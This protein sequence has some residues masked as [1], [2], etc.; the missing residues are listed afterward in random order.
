MSDSRPG[1]FDNGG[2]L[3]SQTLLLGNAIFESPA[4]PGRSKPPNG[5]NASAVSEPQPIGQLGEY[6]L[7]KELG[8][9]GMGVV[10][11]AMQ[12]SLN[13]RVAVKT[14][15]QTARLEP[16]QV[17]RFLHEAQAAAQLNHPHIVPVFSVG[18]ADGLHYYTMQLIEGRDVARYIRE[19]RSLCDSGER[20]GNAE[21]PVN[22]KRPTEPHPAP[23]R[24]NSFSD[25]VPGDGTTVSV[26]VAKFA[27]LLPGKQERTS[28]RNSFDEIVQIGIQ[29]AEALHYAHQVGVVHRDVKPSNL[30]L[31]HEGKLW[32][33]DFGLAQVQGAAAMTMTGEVVGTLRYMSPEQPLGQRVLLD[34]RTDI[35]S[36]GVTL[37]ELLTLEKAFGGTT[38]REIIRQV[39]FDEPIRIRRRNSRVPED[40]ET[41]V[42]KAM[43]KNPDERYQTAR[44]LAD[45]LERFRQDQAILARR[46]TLL[47]QGRR[48]VR[49]NVA[50]ATAITVGL[51][52]LL[53]VS[54]SASG[55]I[56]SA[57]QAETQQRQKVE[58]ALK[59]SEGLRLAASSLLVNG[60]NPGLAL[61]LA[62]R[63][64]ELYPCVDTNSAL[65]TAMSGNHELFSF[66]PREKRSAALSFSPDGK[67]I[68]SATHLASAI[69]TTL[70]LLESEPTTG[71]LLRTYDDGGSMICGVYSPDG[72]LMLSTSLIS[73]DDGA[74]PKTA[75]VRCVLWDTETGERRFTFSD[76]LRNSCCDRVFSSAR[77][78]V[79]IPGSDGTVKVFSTTDGRLMKSLPGHTQPVVC[80]SF[81]QR[82]D[83]I[84]SAS[85]DESVRVWSS[86]TGQ[87]IQQF[88][89]E[90]GAK[91]IRAEI[92]KSD[93]EVLISSSKGT[94]VGSV[95]TGQPRNPDHL[96]ENTAV[97]DRSGTTAALYLLY[98]KHVNIVDVPSCQTMAR[99]VVDSPIAH[100]EFSADSKNL[101]VCTVTEAI[102]A[103]AATGQIH[104]RLR[105]HTGAMIEAR[106]SP[107][108]RTVVSSS[109]DKT[110]RHW[111]LDNW[112]D[113][114]IISTEMERALP[115]PWAI[116]ADS[117]QIAVAVRPREFTELRDADGKLINASFP[118]SVN[119][120]GINGSRLVT[121]DDHEIVVWNSESLQQVA[122]L[123]LPSEQLF[124]ARAVPRTDL[125][126]ALLHDRPP[127]IW[128]IRTGDKTYVKEAT[129]QPSDMDLH[130]RDSIVAVCGRNGDCCL[131]DAATARVTQAFHQQRDCGTVRFSP[132][133][134]NI[135]T[136]DSTNTIV[137]WTPEQN[138]NRQVFRDEPSG[139]LHAAWG[140]DDTTI[141]AWRSGTISDLRCLNTETGAEL[142]RLPDATVSGLSVHPAETVAAI[143]SAESGLRLWNWTTSDIRTL[144]TAPARTPVFHRGQLYA[145]EGSADFQATTETL[146]GFP[147]DLKFARSALSIRDGQTGQLKEST[148]LTMLVHLL[149]ADPESGRIAVSG[150]NYI[151]EVSS[152]EDGNRI[153]DIRQ[154]TAPL[155]FITFAGNTTRL[156]C[157]GLDGRISVGDA[158]G[159]RLLPERHN[160]PIRIAQVS[161]DGGRLA[162]IDTSGTG[163]L[164][165]LDR[166]EFIL[167]L[168]RMEAA[169]NVLEMSPSN[170][171]LAMGSADGTLV[172]FDLIART[173]ISVRR[174]AA[175]AEV[176]WSEDG[177]QLLV[178][179]EQKN[180]DPVTRLAP[181]NVLVLNA[182]TL[183]ATSIISVREPRLA[184]WR[185]GRRQIGIV[186]DDGRLV[187]HDPVRNASVIEMTMDRRRI[188]DMAFSPNGQDLLLMHEDELSL[189]NLDSQR[190]QL[191][192]PS[193][194][195][196]FLNEETKPFRRWQPFSPDGKWILS[197]TPA[198][199]KS[200]RV[201]LEEARQQTLRPLSDSE[202]KQYSVGT[203]IPNL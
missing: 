8:R 73:S 83:R 2:E 12:P 134:R 191:R 181:R 9:G 182:Q 199:K 61:L 161:R 72:R 115:Y 65:M 55:M 99:I 145:V 14:L 110:I 22:A 71:K 137:V 62:A 89:L 133:G 124:A 38:S 120:R 18:I 97:A 156:I 129:D 54:L 132:S 131:I 126:V 163:F 19:A 118:G 121:H 111:S 25:S 44:E 57:L 26:P 36:L 114:Q 53:L 135:L 1:E 30:M 194:D 178:V 7:L 122:S 34:Q 102:V 95:E 91:N 174:D 198:L 60:S 31:D 119:R 195:K 35:Y 20:R 27:G 116:S 157:G 202:R 106:F 155:P 33:T 188:S 47:Q 179:T 159:Q 52:C 108:G 92:L 169:V 180:P 143:T 146:F 56:W 141:L 203:L 24:Q 6:I 70:P 101:L 58:S 45:D 144:T 197:T 50:L 125:I 41:I 68:L 84:V 37:Y 147:D 10:Y 21:T 85:E 200:P 193:S 86:E 148:P 48:W 107:N 117:Q 88:T 3:S 98:G 80:C 167:D 75:A 13:R 183:K 96:R 151:A 172:L 74:D 94:F 123:R 66:S 93:S 152:L 187:L 87:P 168:P 171:R 104:A 138:I 105:G 176:Q 4:V 166:G 201:P 140:Q 154:H 100:A 81:S 77:D 184:A 69:G 173:S 128:N 136:I 139:R 175:I 11:E 153:A 162:S 112:G 185:P 150:L 59:Q 127:L 5:D 196:T 42:M 170:V 32:V 189:W 164:W 109:H 43:A 15:P 29:A 67:R 51:V 39:C 186:T 90:P 63:A 192:I 113:R 79:V 149:T 158:S 177:N 64:A 78:E 82:G 190:E 40:L 142:G 49:R 46:P 160:A 165:D 103:D 28:H 17:Q 76:V 130:P 16:R 23:A